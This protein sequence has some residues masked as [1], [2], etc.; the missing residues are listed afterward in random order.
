MCFIIIF[1]LDSQSISCS[2]DA[3]VGKGFACR[4]KKYKKPYFIALRLYEI[5]SQFIVRSSHI[6]SKCKFKW[7]CF[8][9]PSQRKREGKEGYNNLSLV[10]C[11]Q[12]RG[13]R[14]TG[15]FTFQGQAASRFR[16]AYENEDL[17]VLSGYLDFRVRGQ[18]ILMAH[19]RM[20]HSAPDLSLW[21]NQVLSFLVVCLLL[22]FVSFLLFSCNVLKFWDCLKARWRFRENWG[23]KKRERRAT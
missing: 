14:H 19:S 9:A 10:L 1:N 13:N 18:D 11:W 21:D 4:Y 16:G 15:S 5:P 8:T 2:E 17:R 22:C 23:N 12:I 7:K 20:L 3:T 6:Y